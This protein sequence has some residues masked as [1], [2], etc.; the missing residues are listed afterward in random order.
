[1]KTLEESIATAMDAQ[2]TAIVP[3]LPY[4]LQDFWEIG[5]PAE[6]SL[7][8]YLEPNFMTP[9]NFWQNENRFSQTVS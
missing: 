4:I 1:M 8:F 7:L 2:D 3:F 5:T 6:A 9:S